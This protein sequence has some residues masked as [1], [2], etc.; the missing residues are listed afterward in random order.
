MTHVRRSV[1]V[2][3]DIETCFDYIADP[4]LAPLFLSSLYSITP[5]DIEPRGEGNT[6]GWEYDL[7]GVALKGES[8]CIVYDRPHEYTW[9]ATTRVDTTWR[10]RFEEVPNGTA[11]T[12]DVEYELQDDMLGKIADA[13]VIERLNEHEGDAA[14]RNLRIILSKS[15][16]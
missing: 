15:G 12:L 8:K 10:Y 9:Q 5:I 6:W 16:E 14:V 3:A 1:T 11:I 7:Y 13:S 2:D 4:N